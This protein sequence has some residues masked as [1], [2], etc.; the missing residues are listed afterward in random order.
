MGKTRS[1]QSALAGILVLAVLAVPY[2]L[3]GGDSAAG[4]LDLGSLLPPRRRP[5][6]HHCERLRSDRAHRHRRSRSDKDQC[7]DSP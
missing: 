6:H 1:R 7:P 3:T 4:K 2:G 5:N